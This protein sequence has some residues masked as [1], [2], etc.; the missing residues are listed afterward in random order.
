MSA[1][2]TKKLAFETRKL[3]VVEADQ[4]LEPATESQEPV[5]NGSTPDA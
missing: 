4:L 5:A 1:A 3:A 2:G